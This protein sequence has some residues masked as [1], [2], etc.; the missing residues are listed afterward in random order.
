MTHKY[1]LLLI[2]FLPISLFSQQS[3]LSLTTSFGLA[4]IEGHNGF[5]GDGEISFPIYKKLNLGINYNTMNSSKETNPVED[6]ASETI[7]AGYFELPQGYYHSNNSRSQNSVGIQLSYNMIDSK[8]ILFSIGGGVNYNLYKM[9]DLRINRLNPEITLSYNKWHQNGFG[10]QLS[11]DI[12]Y[13]ITNA[14]SVGIRSRLM[15]YKDYN[16]SIMFATQ[17]KLGQGQ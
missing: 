7:T 2:S 4:N 16:G 10:T 1:I 9:L 14:V 11:T 13:K 17:V 15:E 6:I 8:R 5:S 3:E 12:L